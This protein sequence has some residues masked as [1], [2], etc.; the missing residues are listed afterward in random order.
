MVIGEFDETIGRREIGLG[1]E[2]ADQGSVSS[3]RAAATGM[4][5]MLRIA[6]EEALASIEHLPVT[7]RP[8]AEAETVA[9]LDRALSRARRVV[10][11]L[12]ERASETMGDEGLREAA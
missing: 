8:A 11:M 7:C 2:P 12:D 3:R 9:R 4:L 5:R 1:A 10:A 6:R